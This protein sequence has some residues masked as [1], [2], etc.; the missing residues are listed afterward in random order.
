MFLPTDES[1]PDLAEDSLRR[2]AVNVYVGACKVAQR[3]QCPPI[4]GFQYEPDVPI[5]LKEVPCDGKTKLKRHIHPGCG[6]VDVVD[7]DTGQVVK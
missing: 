1:V 7:L 2:S 3:L 6:R 4:H 5:G